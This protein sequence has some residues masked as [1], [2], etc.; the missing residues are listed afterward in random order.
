MLA[1]FNSVSDSVYAA[2]DIQEKLHAENVFQLRIG[3][4]LGEVVFENNDVFGD[5]V[6]IA[7]RIQ[8]TAEPGTIYVSE[9][10]HDN[11]YNKSGIS[12]VFV[13]QENL[14][15]VRELVRMYEVYD[16]E[17][18]QTLHRNES[19]QSINGSEKSIAILPFVNMSN[20]PDQEYFS[21]GMAEEILNALARISKSLKWPAV[22]PPSSSKGKI[23]TCVKWVKNLGL[24]TVLEGSVRKYG[25]RLRITAQLVDINV[26]DGFHSME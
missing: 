19:S 20:D 6:N 1:S 17:K 5:G 18:H 10:V 26:E 23:L 9:T 3:I 15:N 16:P 12:S 22:R 24:P 2:M 14:K 7:S 13:K 8:A 21:D 25:N 11:L 4:H